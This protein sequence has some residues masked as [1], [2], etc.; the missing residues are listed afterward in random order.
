V[1]RERAYEYVRGYTIANDYAIREYLEN[2]YRPNLR[3]K[4]RDGCTPLGPFV[5]DRDD[6]RDPMA[7]GLITRVNERVVQE[8]NT[9]DMLFDIPALIAYL[10]SFMTLQRD[11]LILTG[12]PR[13]VVYLKHG[14]RVSTEIEGIGALVNTIV[15]EPQELT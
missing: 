8:G 3:V 9:R 15:D 14:D 11:D 1:P 6:I 13:G 4:N 10:T 5:V 7:L 2:Y 12:T